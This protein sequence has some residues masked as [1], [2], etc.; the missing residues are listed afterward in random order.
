MTSRFTDQ[1]RLRTEA[2]PPDDLISGGGIEG[3]NPRIRVDVGE[4][5]FFDG[6]QFRTFLEYNL[7]AA[8]TLA[9]KVTIPINII[10]YGLSLEVITGEARLSTVAG[11]T[12]GGTFSTPLPIIARNSMT[13]RPTPLYVPQVTL[14]TGGTHTDGTVIDL[15]WVK[16]ADNANFSTSVGN[17][18]GDERGVGPGLAYFRL[19]AV[20]A[21]A[22]V[23][24]ARW[25]ERL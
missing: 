18:I 24:R 8:A 11:G 13:E 14:A 9:I 5:S 21:A 4:P 2:T 17:V 25:E 23:I 6:R 1:Q 3:T 10:L 12:E 22:G 7:A 20:S 19:E 16:T 15:L